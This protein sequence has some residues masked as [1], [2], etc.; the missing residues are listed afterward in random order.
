MARPTKYDEEILKETEDYI[1]GCEDDLDK[2]KVELPSLEGLAFRLRVNKD[3]IQEWRKEHE[4]FSVL[5]SQLLSKQGR[6]LVNKGLSGAYNPTIAKVL[7]TKHGYREGIDTTS[8]EKTIGA[9]TPEALAI[10]SAF[11]IWYKQHLHD[12]KSPE[13]PTGDS[14]PLDSRMDS[15]QSDKD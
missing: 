5:I 6:A 13:K 10:A 14:A 1:S 8:N 9:T 12:N 11:D 3:T 4:E 15:E 2:K 7:L